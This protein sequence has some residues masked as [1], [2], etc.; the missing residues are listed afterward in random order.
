MRVDICAPNRL[1]NFNSLSL[2]KALEV[3]PVE[4]YMMV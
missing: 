2:Y 3:N 4:D 1:M